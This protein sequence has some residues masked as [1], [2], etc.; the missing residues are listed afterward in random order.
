MKNRK[1]DWLGW[2][3]LVSILISSYLMQTRLSELRIKIEQMQTPKLEIKDVEQ[4]SKLCEQLT[5]QWSGTGYAFYLLQPKSPIKTY[6][7]KASTSSNLSN[8]PLRVDISSKWYVSNLRKNKYLVANADDARDILDTSDVITQN[9]IIVPVY[10][11][12]III[13]ELYMT[14]DNATINPSIIQAKM[15]EA[16]V[17]SRLIQ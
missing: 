5:Q 9:F 1:I 7:E 3:I 17:L 4:F 15:Y 8:L 6:K 14:Y 2:V 13:G 16:Q 10:Q 11:H 12:N